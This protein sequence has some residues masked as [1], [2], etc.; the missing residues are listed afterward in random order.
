MGHYILLL[1]WTDQG[2]RG[3]KETPKRAAAF[4]EMVKKMGGESSIYYT[5]GQHDIVA[6]LTLPNDESVVKLNL[7]MGR[8]GNVRTTTLKGWTK[9]EMAGIISSLQG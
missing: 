3:V 1:N 5:L 8:L 6:V 7:E 9:Q 4:E 2:I